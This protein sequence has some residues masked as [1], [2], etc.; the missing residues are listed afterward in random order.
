MKYYA[1]NSPHLLTHHIK[2]LSKEQFLIKPKETS[3]I[4]G[5]IIFNRILHEFT[6]M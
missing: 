6:N 4:A 5:N 3:P 2:I 1:T